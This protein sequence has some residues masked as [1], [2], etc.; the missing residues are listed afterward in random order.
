MKIKKLLI[1][2]H[3]LFGPALSES[4]SYD[5]YKLDKNVKLENNFKTPHDSDLVYFGECDLRHP[6]N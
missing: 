6:D 4:L 3:N 1:D 5:E 2:S